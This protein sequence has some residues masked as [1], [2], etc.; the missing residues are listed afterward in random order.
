[1]PCASFTNDR[2]AF[3]KKRCQRALCIHRYRKLAIRTFKKVINRVTRGRYF[4]EAD[5]STDSG[6]TRRM[7][8]AHSGFATK[9]ATVDSVVSVVRSFF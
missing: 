4:S 8:S 1:M 3:K 9:T 7:T 6:T 2:L 5:A